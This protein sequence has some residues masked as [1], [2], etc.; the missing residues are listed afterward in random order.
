[1]NFH[2]LEPYRAN[3]CLIFRGVKTTER[4]FMVDLQRAR[5]WLTSRLHVPS[6]AGTEPL[7]WQGCGA[8]AT[9][10]VVSVSDVRAP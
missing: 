8:A 3:R 10:L 6:D 9:L 5:Q 2:G 1:M 4:V 7:A